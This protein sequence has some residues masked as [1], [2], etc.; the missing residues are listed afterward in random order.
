M[1][2]RCGE[3]GDTASNKT[4]LYHDSSIMHLSFLN[5]IYISATMKIS[6]YIFIHFG[7]FM[8]IPEMLGQSFT[9]TVLG[10][11]Y[12]FLFLIIMVIVISLAAKVIK[13]LKLDRDDAP[14][15]AAPASNGSQT[16]VVAA[17]ATAVRE[18]QNG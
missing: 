15:A 7:G 4:V 5:K 1:K 9:L 2:N 10:M 13:L 18:K 8:T 17:I 16:A 3:K 11:A 12:V 14:A 6:S